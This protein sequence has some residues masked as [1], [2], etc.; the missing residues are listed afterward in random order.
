MTKRFLIIVIAFIASLTTMHAQEVNFDE[1]LVA[2]YTLQ[3][4]RAHV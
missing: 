2:P 3:I 1:S 4:G